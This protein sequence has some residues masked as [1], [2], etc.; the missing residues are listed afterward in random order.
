MGIQKLWDAIEGVAAS[1]VAIF[2]LSSAKQNKDSI[3]YM[4]KIPPKYHLFLSSLEL[5]IHIIK[6]A[7]NLHVRAHQR[8]TPI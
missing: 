1:T 7:Y 2:S 5:G 8:V 6:T 3:N 4:T